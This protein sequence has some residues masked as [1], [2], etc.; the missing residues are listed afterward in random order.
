MTWHF[1]RRWQNL[2]ALFSPEFKKKKTFQ[3]GSNKTVSTMFSSGQP[4][5]ANLLVEQFHPGK[6]SS[7]CSA[8]QKMKP[9][10]VTS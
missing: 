4:S 8:L 2:F 1:D 5:R 7:G 3:A 9:L 6:N 10:P